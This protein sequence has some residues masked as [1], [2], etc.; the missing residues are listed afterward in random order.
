MATMNIKDFQRQ[1]GKFVPHV[2][3]ISEDTVRKGALGIGLKGLIFKTP[4]DEGVARGNWNVEFDK[5]DT[6]VKENAKGGARSASRGVNK[7]ERFKLGQTIYFTNALPYIIP[8]E[9]G[10]STQAPNGMLRLTYQEL[11]N[12]FRKTG[13][14]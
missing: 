11:I 5:K 12:Y 9:F 1:A 14:K 2:K 8:L 6:S 13:K 3:G 10:W 7:L 4:V